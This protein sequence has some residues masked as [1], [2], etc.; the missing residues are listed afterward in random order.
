MLTLTA[1]ILYYT[2]CLGYINSTGGFP[3]FLMFFLQPGRFHESKFL[4]NILKT[5]AYNKTSASK[6]KIEDVLDLTS[7]SKAM[8]DFNCDTDFIRQKTAAAKSFPF[9]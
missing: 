7:C 5:D 6:Q 4:H 3:V 2:L 9:S 1:N 8:E